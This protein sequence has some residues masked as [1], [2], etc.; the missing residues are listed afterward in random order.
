MLSHAGQEGTQD[1][2]FASRAAQA[3]TLAAAGT[4]A[5]RAAAGAPALGMAAEAVAMLLFSCAGLRVLL[6]WA[7]MFLV[8]MAL[9]KK[10]WLRV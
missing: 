3:K 5:P 1:R 9:A 4:G 8:R 6:I 10:M 2:Y 7:V